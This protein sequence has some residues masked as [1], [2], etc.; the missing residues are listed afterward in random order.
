[1]AQFFGQRGEI[2]RGPAMGFGREPHVGDGVPFDAVGARL[3]QDELGLELAQ[4]REHP[5]PLGGKD[6]IVR[7]R[8]H[9][10]VELGARR[11][12]AADFLLATRAGVQVAAVLVDVGEY[13]VRIALESVVHAVAVVRIDVHVSN[14][15]QDRDSGA[16]FPPPRRSR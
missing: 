11:R 12:A 8:R 2:A 10:N 14:A 3:E 9:G 5:R 15:F 16:A 6:R 7:T 1:M 13:Q 4:V